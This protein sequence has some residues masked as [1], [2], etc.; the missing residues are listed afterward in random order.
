MTISKKSRL[1]ASALTSVFALSLFAGGCTRPTAERADDSS[2][3]FTAACPLEED[4]FDAE[5]M[6]APMSDDE[7]KALEDEVKNAAPEVAPPPRPATETPTIPMPVPPMAPSADGGVGVRSMA[8]TTACACVAAD[9]PRRAALKEAVKRRNEDY[10]ALSKKLGWGA[11]LGAGAGVLAIQVKN[12]KP[13]THKE[14]LA[15]GITLAAG[16]YAAYLAG[17]LDI[18][19]TYKRAYEEAMKLSNEAPQCN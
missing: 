2:S 15:L 6:P 14:I 19:K 18:E 8:M 5:D 10:A 7:L 12:G 1:T 3:A 16:V 4:D 13:P 11:I 9:S 17:V